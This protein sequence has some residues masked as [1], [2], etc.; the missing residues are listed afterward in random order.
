MDLVKIHTKDDFKDAVIPTGQALVFTSLDE[1]GNPVT[2]YKDEGGNF[3]T[4]AGGGNSEVTVTYG[5][6]INN[7]DGTV[8]FQQVTDGVAVGDPITVSVINITN[9]GVDQPNYGQTDS[10]NDQPNPESPPDTPAVPEVTFAVDLPLSSLTDGVSDLGAELGAGAAWGEIDAG[11]TGV[12]LNIAPIA[13]PHN[14][15]TEFTASV[16]FKCDGSR[17]GWAMCFDGS[18]YG[19]YVTSAEYGCKVRLHSYVNNQSSDSITVEGSGEP[20]VKHHTFTIVRSNN[21][22]KLYIDG[23]P[24]TSVVFDLGVLP[25]TSYNVYLCGDEDFM[26]SISAATGHYCDLKI[27]DIA[28]TDEQ[29]ENYLY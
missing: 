15:G 7:G 9:T 20:W 28:L 11:Q 18:T 5:Y 21:T 6:F 2:M 13:V 1:S 29:I 8:S 14:F 22:V 26:N 4:I 19:L 24:A 27:A 25:Q 16:K 12:R 17:S 3:G 10:E 23:A